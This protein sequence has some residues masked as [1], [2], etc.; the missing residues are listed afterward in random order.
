MIGKMSPITFIIYSLNDGEYIGR[1]TNLKNRIKSHITNGL[2]SHTKKHIVLGCYHDVYV[3]GYGKLSP[4]MEFLWYKKLLPNT[5]KV[6]PGHRYY[7]RDLKKHSKEDL[8][9]QYEYFETTYKVDHNL[10]HPMAFGENW[11]AKTIST[12][13][14]N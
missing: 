13:E 3:K 8:L 6:I 7:L 12:S 5:N 9:N 1:T 10:T 4:R 11:T 14:S 2:L